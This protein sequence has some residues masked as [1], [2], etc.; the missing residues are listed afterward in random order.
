MFGKSKSPTVAIIGA[1]FGGLSAAITLQN[2]GIQDF[3]LFEASTR[4][5]GTWWDNQYPGC[6]VDVPSHMYSFPFKRHDWTRTHAKQAELHAYLEETVVDYGLAPKIRLGVPVERAVW[7]ESTHAWTL[8]LGHGET[9]VCHILISAVGFL[10]VPQ[11]PSWP[12]L[13]LFEGPKF[14]T[15]RWEHQHDLA[16]RTVAIVGTGSSAT[17]IVPTIAPIVKHL[18]LFQREPGWVLP[19]GDHDLTPRRAQEMAQPAALPLGA[20]QGLLVDRAR[21]SGAATSGSPARGSTRSARPP[22]SPT[23]TRSS[24]IVRI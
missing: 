23:S 3:T 6:E 21:S 15:A 8:S 12:G 10:N 22:P 20:D 5:G 16:G 14:H 7:D 24:P 19:K 9:F 2:A 17:Q 13:E 18:H 4:V 11:Y 1:G